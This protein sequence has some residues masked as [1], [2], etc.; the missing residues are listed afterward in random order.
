MREGREK[1]EAT[2]SEPNSSEAADSGLWPL[3]LGMCIGC[4]QDERRHPL[5]PERRTFGGH[6][7]QI[8]HSRIWGRK[9][10]LVAASARGVR[11]MNGRST[12][13]EQRMTGVGDV[14]VTTGIRRTVFKSIG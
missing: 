9:D 14:K 3:R 2:T 12:D 8:Q 13:D 4:V 11:R 5:R 10:Q 7:P 1:D 6:L